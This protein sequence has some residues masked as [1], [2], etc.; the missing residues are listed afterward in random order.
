MVTSIGISGSSPSANNGWRLEVPPPSDKAQTWANEISE[1]I[2][3]G[4][5]LDVP[6]GKLIGKL[7]LSLRQTFRQIRPH[8]APPFL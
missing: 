7:A 6:L 5:I 1:H 4:T 3:L 8:P 2:K